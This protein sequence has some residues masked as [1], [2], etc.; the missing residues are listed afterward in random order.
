[1]DKIILQTL[2][3]KYIDESELNKLIH[4]SWDSDYGVL[5]ELLKLKYDLVVQ[6]KHERLH[7]PV[8]SLFSADQFFRSGFHAEI[9]KYA[10]L[11]QKDEY[12]LKLFECFIDTKLNSATFDLDYFCMVFSLLEVAF[13]LNDFQI[14][15]DQ[16][17][18]LCHFYSM[19]SSVTHE[20]LMVYISTTTEKLISKVSASTSLKCLET[21]LTCKNP[22]IM[23]CVIEYF[24]LTDF[25]SA[26][27]DLLHKHN[28]WEEIDTLIRSYETVNQRQGIFLLQQIKHFYVDN[29]LFTQLGSHYI[30]LPEFN[31]KDTES[32]WNAFFIL[33]HVSREK[34]IHL[35]K[36][37]LTFLPDLFCLHS[38]WVKTLYCILLNHAQ[39]EIVSLTATSILTSKWFVK[40]DNFLLLRACLVEALSKIDYSK[41]TIDTFVA[42][43]GYVNEC[44]DETFW[45]L[46]EDIIKIPWNPINMWLYCKNIFKR[47]HV[48]RTQCATIS[49]FLNYLQSLPHKYIRTGCMH[50][51]VKFFGSNQMSSEDLIKLAM[52]VNN[53][54]VSFEY[55]CNTF[56]KT[57]LKHKISL[58]NKVQQLPQQEPREVAI[59]LRLWKTLD[60]TGIIFQNC[61]L[62]KFPMVLLSKIL[63]TFDFVFEQIDATI[64]FN[65]LENVLRSC[66]REMLE[67]VKYFIKKLSS[68]TTYCLLHN[69]KILHI[70]CLAEN[71]IKQSTAIECEVA[72]SILKC[73]HRISLN[74]VDICEICLV[75]GKEESL[76]IELLEIFFENISKDMATKTLKIIETLYEKNS[77]KVTA[78]VIRNL[79]LFITKLETKDVIRE[80]LQTSFQQILKLCE[81]FKSTLEAYLESV[82]EVGPEECCEITRLVLALSCKY[83]FVV[84]ILTAHLKR[85]VVRYPQS[86]GAY[87]DIFVECLLS[88][89]C[90]RK[91]ER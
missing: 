69:D 73:F 81:L 87:V 14:K 74:I 35:V 6:G 33:S 70:C 4:S 17:A 28:I 44:S 18:S 24:L 88:D 82:Q 55:F 9:L 36:P 83:S 27:C 59:V 72:L 10:L 86:V 64:V 1:M 80:I 5:R 41:N 56:K 38:L 71:V 50:L 67:D 85:V 51:C 66:D 13:S 15:I 65:F 25:K 58:E 20:E 11:V 68:N 12:E 61:D 31:E 3:L 34:Q 63:S 26:I 32:A 21:I 84:P 77:D 46:L 22:N 62:N 7:L 30:K 40:I 53:T 43:G 39:N 78:A 49:Q 90:V 79:A 57:I 60:H 2:L 45:I 42:L 52:V 19:L 8:H 76:M 47:K 23:C 29:K 75:N 16:P 89:A 37:S 91:E 48:G 54:D